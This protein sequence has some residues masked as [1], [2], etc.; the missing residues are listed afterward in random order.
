MRHGPAGW[1]GQHV[2]RYGPVGQAGLLMSPP[3]PA[4]IMTDAERLVFSDEPVFSD[5]QAEPGRLSG[6]ELR[7][8]TP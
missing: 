2:T 6:R 3:S 1:E 8:S 4:E 5:E 7:L